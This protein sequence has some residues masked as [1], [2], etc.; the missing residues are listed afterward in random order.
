VPS[1]TINRLLDRLDE[2]KR[3][4]E[5]SASASART[6]KILAAL[7]KRRFTD[8]TALIRFH[9][10]L[11]FMRAY[12][13]SARVLVRVERI[14]KTFSQRIRLLASAG[15][16]LSPLE[17]VEVS[18]IA[19]TFIEE[20]FS[21]QIARWLVRRYPS[22]LLI[23]WELHED[24]YRLAATWPRF[25]PLLEEDS[26]VEANVP[27]VDWLRAAKGRSGSDLKWLI[28]R[29]E[30]LPLSE[31]E[32]AE[33]YESLKIYVRW[34]LDD[35]RA[36]RTLMKRSV[37][38][39]F[40]HRE[41]LLRRSDVSLE[42]E[43]AKPPVPLKKLSR[44]QGEAILDLARETSAV[45]YRELYGFTHGDA[46]RVIKADIGRGVEV[47]I[48]GVPPERRLP[49][50]AYHAGLIFKNGVPVCYVESLTICERMEIGFN[51]YYTFRE[52]ESAWLYARVL[53]ILRQLMGVTVFSI[54]PY[55]LGHENEEGIASGAFW[56]YRKLGFRPTLDLTTE[57]LKT[58]ER[59]LAARPLYR[60]SHATLRTL[61]EGH[62]LLEIPP[63]KQSRWDRF[64]IR[65]VG[66]AIQ[67]RM[68][69][70]FGGDAAKM[71]RT[72][73][74]QVARALS[75]RVED[76]K[77]AEQRAFEDLALV[78]ALIPALARWTEDEKR[79]V[80][81]I[82]RAKAGTDES[83]YVQ[84]LQRHSRLRDEIIKIGS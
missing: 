62:M 20:A 70:G 61:A 76:W 7:E 55:Q 27:Y 23:D 82:I 68:A 81:R 9:E 16:D 46:A 45:R 42:S 57:I 51:L 38:K 28:E 50:R 77:T 13:Q 69:T 66:L 33:L 15:A 29:F 34:E 19:G 14:L 37:R 48:M 47:F 40:Y 25:L 6:L 64:R 58:E 73:V 59:R 71:R 22:R 26:L 1:D 84:L 24:E 3:R 79:D 5:A 10:I 63:A 75:V 2:Q 21:Y 53:K 4:F 80:A 30:R 60:T 41:A 72:S 67:R 36:T 32:K 56:F 49:L 12:P 35:S 83:R 74:K 39:V 65:N 18:G 54:D 31:K 52:G 8:A 11:L 78:L 43:F 44:A 17:Y